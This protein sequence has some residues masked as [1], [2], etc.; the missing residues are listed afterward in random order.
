MKKKSKKAR[1][2]LPHDY[3]MLGD[4]FENFE[5]YIPEKR[6]REEE[7]EDAAWFNRVCSDALGLHYG[8]QYDKGHIGHFNFSGQGPYFYLFDPFKKRDD[9]AKVI[10]HLSKRVD[11]LEICWSFEEE[12]YKT[13]S[14]NNV[15]F[16]KLGR[17]AVSNTKVCQFLAAA[18]ISRGIWVKGEE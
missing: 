10:F 7:W 18:M 3:R 9:L 17:Y 8:W 11:Y 6:I 15:G 12:F 13:Y 1:S 5:G 14:K 2:D 16:E 4:L